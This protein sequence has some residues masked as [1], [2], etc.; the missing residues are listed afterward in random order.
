MRSHGERENYM[1]MMI[2]KRVAMIWTLGG[3][4]FANDLRSFAIGAT[5]S[6][7]EIPGSRIV[8]GP[9]SVWGVAV[10]R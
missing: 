1:A 9:G 7:T 6:L 3:H 2:V 10:T 8:R 4:G 5:G